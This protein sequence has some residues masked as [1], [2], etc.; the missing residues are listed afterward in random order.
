VSGILEAASG[1]LWLSTNMGLSRFDP[2]SEVFKR[3]DASDGLQSN[4]FNM[5]AY[6]RSD[7]GEMF[8]GGINGFN[9]FFPA[10][11]TDSEYIPP[12]VISDFKLFNVSVRIGQDTPLRE[13][14]V[15]ADVITLSHEEDFFEIEYAALHYSAPEQNQYAYML[16]GLDK[17]WNYVGNRRFAGYTGVRPGEYT[18]RVKGSNGDGVWNEQG[19]ALGVVITPPYWQTWWFRGSL[20]ALLIGSA[21][22]AATWRIR[23]SEVQR[24]RL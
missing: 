2:A 1:Y 7:G 10:D 24:R 21:I 17:D 19:A 12:L 20:A 4:E 23:A 18:F 14:I 11:I 16:E 8:F 6:H 22:G 15:Q 3:Y 5:S 9:A 13:S